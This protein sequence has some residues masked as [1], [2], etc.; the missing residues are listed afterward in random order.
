MIDVRSALT[1]NAKALSW[2]SFFQDAASEMLYPVAESRQLDG[3]VPLPVRAAS[4]ALEGALLGGELL[5][6]VR[7][8]P[9]APPARRPRGRAGSPR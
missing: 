8:R 9:R 1:R 2:V 7:P 3:N 6:G 5:G 4:R